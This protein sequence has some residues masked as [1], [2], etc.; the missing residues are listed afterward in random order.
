MQIKSKNINSQNCTLNMPIDG[1]VEVTNGIAEVSDELGNLLLGNPA[2]WEATTEEVEELDEEDE[3]SDVPN[4]D[5]LDELELPDLIEMAKEAKLK[6]YNLFTK[7][8]AKMRAFL[9]KKLK[10]AAPPADKIEE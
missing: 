1:E 10:A 8:A 7:D 9:R 4:E 6:G 5:G 2:D 3:G